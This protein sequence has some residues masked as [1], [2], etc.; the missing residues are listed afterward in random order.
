ML[1]EYISLS[2]SVPKGFLNGY[3]KFSKG[4]LKGADHFKFVIFFI[5]FS[6]IDV[7]P[8]Y[9]F[10]K[11]AQPHPPQKLNGLPVMKFKKV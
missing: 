5:H 1:V 11:I 9:I 7:L 10:Y 8:G 3:K 6:C 4:F 2:W